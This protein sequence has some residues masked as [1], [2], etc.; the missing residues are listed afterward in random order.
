MRTQGNLKLRESLTLIKLNLSFFSFSNVSMV[1]IAFSGDKKVK[2]SLPSFTV[3]NLITHV[4]N[5][6]DSSS[7]NK[8]KFSTLLI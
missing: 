7:E 4:K 3:F 2:D 5:A 1:S 8:S 6:L